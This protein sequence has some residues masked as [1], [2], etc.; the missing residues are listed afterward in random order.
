MICIE[1]AAAEHALGACDLPS[2]IDCYSSLPHLIYAEREF[3]P[4]HKISYLPVALGH[5][6]AGANEH[7]H[8]THAMCIEAGLHPSPALLEYSIRL[9]FTRAGGGREALPADQLN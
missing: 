5:A 1:M 2:R 4:S 9:R 3:A 8:E 7:V 6:A